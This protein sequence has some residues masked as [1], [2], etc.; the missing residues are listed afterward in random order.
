MKVV[1]YNNEA[2]AEALQLRLHNRLNGSGVKYVADRYS[3][4]RTRKNGSVDVFIK[5]SGDTWSEVEAEIT[6]LE[7]NNIEDYNP[8]N[9]PQDAP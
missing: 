4:I 8:N 6:P 3:D 2:Q 9:Y 1:N 5:D 7:I